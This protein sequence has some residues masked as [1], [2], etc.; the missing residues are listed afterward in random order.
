MGRRI[1]LTKGDKKKILRKVERASKK[2]WRNGKPKEKY[3]SK[4]LAD[5]VVFAMRY[6]GKG[7]PTLSSY[8]CEFCGKYHIG[9][10]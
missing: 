9:N 2:C 3:D 5:N 4:E 6:S 8:L 10:N 7:S 1:F